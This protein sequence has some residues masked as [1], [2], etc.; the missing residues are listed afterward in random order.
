MAKIDRV[1]KALVTFLADN[2]NE[3]REVHIPRWRIIKKL[4]HDELLL[5]EAFRQLE[6]EGIIEVIRTKAPTGADAPNVYRLRG[7]A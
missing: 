5:R 1:R 4:K 3:N 6:A 2:A 7:D